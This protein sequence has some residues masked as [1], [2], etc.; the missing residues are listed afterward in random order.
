M[1]TMGTLAALAALSAVATAGYAYHEHKKNKKKDNELVTEETTAP[2]K[3]TTAKTAN[4][5]NYYTNESE[6][7]N[8]LFGSQKKTK[9]TLF[10]GAEY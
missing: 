8:T 1:F 2:V 3:K 10:G 9:R 4:I 6:N 5:Y 7:G